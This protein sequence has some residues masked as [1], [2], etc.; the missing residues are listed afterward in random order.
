MAIN[1]QGKRVNHYVDNKELLAHL[2]ERR[3]AIKA[4]EEAGEEPPPVDNYLGK[5]IIDIA[6]H[7]SYRP[8]F[9]NY[10]FKSEMIGD[11][12]ENGLKVVDNFDPA[13]SS[14][15]F[16]YLT[17]IMWNAFIRRIQKEQKEQKIKGRLIEELPL[18]ELFSAQEHDEDGIEYKTHFIEFLRENNFIGVDDDDRPVKK[19]DEKE[20]AEGLE[21]FFEGEKDEQ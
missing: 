17:Q 14:Y 15:P 20:P 4:A 16:A 19:T 11:A 8:N 3:A 2:V 13:K 9:I 1:A 6:T 10:S 7:L 12:I 5:V 18:D 21:L